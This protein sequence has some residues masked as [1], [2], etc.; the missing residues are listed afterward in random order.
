MR[1]GWCRDAYPKS[2]QTQ[3]SENGGREPLEVDRRRRQVGLDARTA[4]I[5]PPIP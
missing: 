1:R 2:D 3:D 4:V 5:R